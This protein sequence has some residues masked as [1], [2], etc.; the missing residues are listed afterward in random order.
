M[1]SAKTME[2]RPKPSIGKTKAKLMEEKSKPMI[3]SFKANS[4]QIY[5]PK[6]N[7]MKRNPKATKTSTRYY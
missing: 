3:V 6:A 7:K 5:N 4:V 1:P 2:V